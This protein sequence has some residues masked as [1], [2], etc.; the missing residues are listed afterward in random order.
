GESYLL[1]RPAHR[2]EPRRAPRQES[3]RSTPETLA[4]HGHGEADPVASKAPVPPDCAAATDPS[5]TAGSSS[6][7][8]LRAMTPSPTAARA[9]RAIQRPMRPEVAVATAAAMPTRASPASPG[10][11]SLPGA[12]AAAGPVTPS[13]VPVTQRSEEHTSELQSRFDL[14]CRLLLE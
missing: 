5:T 2:F 1:D 13:T 3:S 8:A 10:A 6:V 11:A 4:S 9:T 7:R 12:A 14:V